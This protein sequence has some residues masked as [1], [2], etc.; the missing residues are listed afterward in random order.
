MRL[1]PK[2]VDQITVIIQ[3]R[4]IG[5]HLRRAPPGVEFRCNLRMQNPQL[6]FDCRRR[7]HR[8]RRMP[9]H[10]G[11]QLH[12]VMGFFQ[13]RAELVGQRGLAN[14]VRAD[15]REFQIRSEVKALRF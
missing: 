15:E 13:Q 11:D 7:V 8:K 14:S 3:N 10:L 6:S 4:A 5:N 2:L 1:P 12:V 9:R